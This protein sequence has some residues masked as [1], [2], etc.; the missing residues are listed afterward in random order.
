VAD[1]FKPGARRIRRFRWQACIIRQITAI[2]GGV[3]RSGQLVWPVGWAFTERGAFR[4]GRRE[5]AKRKLATTPVTV[6]LPEMA[7]GPGSADR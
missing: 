7:G 6:H 2:A 3:E 5:I 4:V 1:Q